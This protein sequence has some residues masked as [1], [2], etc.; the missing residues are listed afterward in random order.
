MENPGHTIKHPAHLDAP[1]Q[2][3]ITSIKKECPFLWRAFIGHRNEK[4]A[5]V[6]F[7]RKGFEIVG[8]GFLHK[9]DD[10]YFQMYL[11]QG[12]RGQ[13]LGATLVKTA[14]LAMTDPNK[15]L[16]QAPYSVDAARRQAGEHLVDY[17]DLSD[18]E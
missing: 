17:S 1:E 14:E 10:Y 6:I 7:L 5:R 15:A 11:N 13:G 16:I 18:E 2:A 12:Y 3:Y 9:V 8:W 4:D